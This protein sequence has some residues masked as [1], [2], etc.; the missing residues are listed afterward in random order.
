MQS[1]PDVDIEY[2]HHAKHGPVSRLRRRGW[3]VDITADGAVLVPIQATSGKSIVDLER[4]LAAAYATTE[5]PLQRAY[6]PVT[7]STVEHVL[8]ALRAGRTVARASARPSQLDVY[9]CA[10]A[11]WE[12]TGRQAPY[13]L[14]I[15]AL[16][17]ALPANTTLVDH[18]PTAVPD[19]FRR[20][21]E[22]R[23][24]SQ[25]AHPRGSVA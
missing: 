15:E 2:I 13:R 25:S 20:A 23:S 6:E 24:R 12:R 10:A 5:V 22:I 14:V 11:G 3:S 1:D 8:A 17:A 4:L 18:P 7:S 21:I 9:E 16:R 19:L